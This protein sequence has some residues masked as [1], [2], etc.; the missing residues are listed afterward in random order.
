[1][2]NQDLYTFLRSIGTCQHCCLRYLQGKGSEYLNVFASLKKKE[3]TLEDVPTPEDDPKK[4]KE[5]PC[6]ACLGLFQSKIIDEITEA[7]KT[8]P[9]LPKYDC[10][11]V[12]AAFS[13]PII[14]QLRQLILWV[15]LLKRF[16][17]EFK[18]DEPPDIP[19]KDCFRAIVNQKLVEVLKKPLDPNANGILVTFEFNFENELEILTK[20]TLV[21]PKYF[22]DRSQMSKKF[23]KE[24]LTRNAFEQNFI[25]AK[26]NLVRFKEQYPVPPEIPSYTL[27]MTSVK[28][29]GPIVFV[30]GRYCKFSRRLSQSPWVLDGKKVMEDSVQQYITEQIYEFFQVPENTIIFSSSGREDVDV[31]CLDDGRP[32][33]LEIPDAK[34]ADIPFEIARKMENEVNKCGKISIKDLQVVTR[35]STALLR[36][37]EEDKKKVYRALCAL[38]VPVTDEILQKLTLPEGFT[39]NQTTPI[40]V[41]H[42]RPLLVRPRRIY[43]M[44]ASRTSVSDK[45]LVLEVTT[46]AGTYVKELVHSDFGRSHPS[47]KSLIGEEIDL[48]A[49]DV[50]A[51]DLDWP[52]K[53]DYSTNS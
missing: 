27:E 45:A 41:L 40:R 37:G 15:T 35:E 32:F 38:K 28:V 43:C 24:F 47:C 53:I 9:D 26:I 18:Q 33:I 36:H 46:Q 44:R 6:V 50:M 42:R 34:K 22:K 11:T 52:P 17:G 49:L 3:V 39:I 23:K 1:M 10:P 51:I 19:I 31:R 16:P 29:N 48:V 14:L 2:N 8:H 12:S 25:P 30:A 4:F 20:L 5:N 7:L 13:F 21:N